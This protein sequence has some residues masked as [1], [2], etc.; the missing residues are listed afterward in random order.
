MTSKILT[1]NLLCAFIILLAPISFG[2]IMC[3][4][5]PT[6]KE[7][8]VSHGLD[9]GASEWAFYNSVSSLFAIGGPFLVSAFFKCCGNSRKKTLF[10][11]EVFGA[12]FWLLNMLTKLHIWAGIVARALL[13]LYIG[14]ESSIA[15]MYLVE[16]APDG[17]SGFYGC[18]NQFGIVIGFVLFDFIGSSLDYIEL[19]YV[20]AAICALL[21]I[22]VWFVIESPDTEKKQT[23]EE[24]TISSQEKLTDKKNLCGLLV[25]IAIMFFQQFCGI[26]AILTNL[27]D[28]MNS[29]G[30][31]M[32][33]NYQAGIAS[34]AQGV[35]VVISGIIIDKFGRRIV[36]VISSAVIIIFLLIFALNDKFGWSKVLPL[37]CIFLY[38]LGF[39]LGMGPIPWFII[40][41]HF[42]NPRIR[43]LATQIVTATN[44][45]FAFAIIFLWPVM[46]RSLKMFGS[47]I[48]FVIIVFISLIF[49]LF[50][51]HEPNHESK[52]SEQAPNLDDNLI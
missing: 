39:G 8:Q 50:L 10:I 31:D 4:P 27:K 24:E 34:I 16:I 7:I 28:I 26:N 41:E 1:Y 35:A 48:V 19:D 3:Y 21:A 42:E 23:E 38:Q 36:W 20:G 47:L 33:G 40:P 2:T 25:G 37:I 46:E 52:S 6:A 51:I 43:S 5:S 18:M 14:A 49:G 9:S 22:L 13:G 17:Q 32:D 44:W 30:L 12:I 11:V 29:S 15:P 45:I